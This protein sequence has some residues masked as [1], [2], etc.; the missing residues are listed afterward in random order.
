VTPVTNGTDEGL[1]EKMHI[2]VGNNYPVYLI[3]AEMGDRGEDYR[4]PGHAH[5]WNFP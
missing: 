3:T 2:K 5:R 4:A 1:L